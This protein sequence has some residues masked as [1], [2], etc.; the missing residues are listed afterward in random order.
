[1]KSD[2]DLLKLAAKAAGYVLSDTKPGYPLVVE[3][4][5]AWNPL[6]C[7]GDALRLSVKL[8]IDIKYYDDHL[9]CWYENYL[10][11]GYIHYDGDALA[12]TRRAITLAA[13][14]MAEA[15]Q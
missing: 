2:T 5:G 11:T 10:G 6:E 9:V 8:K 1:M 3:G 15:T 12:A 4:F 13:V 7:D 14:G